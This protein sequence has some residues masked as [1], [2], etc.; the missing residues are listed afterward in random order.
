MNK[1]TAEKPSVI[2]IF[3]D[4]MRKVVNR[5]DAYVNLVTALGTSRDKMSYNRFVRSRPL[6][7]DTLDALYSEN[8]VA[9]RVCDVV[10]EE[11]LRQ[12]YKINVAP[13]SDDES[14]KDLDAASSVGTDVQDYADALGL[15]AKF[16]EARVWGRVFGGGALIL[17][18]DDGATA[19]A[20]TLKEPLNENG[21]SR[22]DHINVIDRRYMHPLSYY[23]DPTDPKFGKAKTFIITP[24]ATS[25]LQAAR[26]LASAVEIHETRLVVFG[27]T[28]TTI[29]T[30]Q[31]NG[32]WDTSVLQRMNTV[33]EQFGVSWQALTHILQDASQGVFKMRGL[34]D[35]LASEETALVMKRL[36]MMDMARSN[37]RAVVLD[38]EGEEFARQNYTWSGID[39]VFEMLM[40]RISAAA[41]MPVTVLMGQSPAGMDATG[42]SDIRWFYD[43]IRSSQ[44]N[45]VK[46]ALE[47]ILRLI[48]L[49]KNGPTRGQ[50]PDSWSVTFPSLWQMSPIEQAD[51]ELKTAQKDDIYLRQQVVSPEEVAVSRFTEDGWSSE[52]Q[53]NLEE[54]RALLEG[55][56]SDDFDTMPTDDPSVTA[57]EGGADDVESQALNGAQVTSLV[58]VATK[59]QAGELDQRSGIYIVMTAIPSIKPEIAMS[60]VGSEDPARKAAR[61]KAL[62]NLPSNPPPNPKEPTPEP[63]PADTDDDDNPPVVKEDRIEQRGSKWVLLSK[64]G[65]EVLG[66]HDTKGQAEA[67]ERAIKAEEGR[68]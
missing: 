55:D 64:D 54:R 13:D 2:P 14:G 8:D 21:I 59:V 31:T 48:M 39:K 23:D 17:G 4:R 60:I 36:D 56:I 10:P 1:N 58:D 25:S 33:L 29:H 51:V 34:L 16:I 68:K 18:A 22:F 19:E 63:N 12:G 15:Q 26:S 11:E 24:Q 42:E 41:R 30:R 62:N 44:T 47:H 65:K 7:I 20:G 38:A 66:E 46:P 45:D 9:A 52:T 50:V 3:G 5:L 40:L 49:T 35:A 67:Q 53:I 28:R 27:G 57:P 43:T 32:G 37:V 61:E 6:D